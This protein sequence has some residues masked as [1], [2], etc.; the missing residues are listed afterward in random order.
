MAG[1]FKK[2]ISKDPIPLTSVPAEDV[3]FITPPPFARIEDLIA[4]KHEA[5]G[6]GNRDSR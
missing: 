3:D 5:C 2:L 6:Y 1:N 4:Q